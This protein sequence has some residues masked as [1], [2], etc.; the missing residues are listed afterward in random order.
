MCLYGHTIFLDYADEVRPYADVLF[1]EYGLDFY[2]S[3]HVYLSKIYENIWK[4][5]FHFEIKTNRG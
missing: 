5:P 4:E 3:G 2:V 1:H